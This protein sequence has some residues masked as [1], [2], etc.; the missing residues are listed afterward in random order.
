MKKKYVFMALAA[1]LA[2]LFLLALVIGSVSM[3]LYETAEIIFGQLFGRASQASEAHI[4]IIY[5]I[6]FP[7]VRSE[8]RRVGKEC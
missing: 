4:N 7:R 5:N 2:V 1:A 8:E 6:R 3:P